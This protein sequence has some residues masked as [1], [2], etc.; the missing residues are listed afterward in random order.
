MRWSRVTFPGTMWWAEPLEYGDVER[1]GVRARPQDP[2]VATIIFYVRDVDA[3]LARLKHA[4]TP[5]ITEGGAP[6]TTNIGMSHGRAVVVT[7]PDGHFVELVQRTTID[8]NAPATEIVGAGVRLTIADTDRTMRLYR[9]LGFQPRVATVASDSNIG[10]LIGA[11]GA[12]VRLTTA[13]VPGEP[14]LVFE[15]AEFQGVDRRPLRTRIQDPGSTKLQFVVRSLESAAG[16]I[17]KAGG[18]IVSTGGT[19]VILGPAG[20]HLIVRDLNNFYLI[21]KQ[22]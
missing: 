11:R 21:L 5:V 20:P 19:P 9:D 13:A 7:D 18:A 17:T 14:R 3:L 4:G 22:Q 8:A 16:K 1:E 10:A 6:V 15:F 12:R 2:G